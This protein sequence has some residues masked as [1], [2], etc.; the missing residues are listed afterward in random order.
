MKKTVGKAP[1]MEQF[2]KLLKDRELKATP[3]RLAVHEAML[4][5]THAGADSVAQ[6]IKEH[7][8]TDISVASVYNILSS[9][10]D[11][12][13]YKRRMSSNNKMYFD[14]IAS[15]HMHLYDT[16]FDEFKDIHDNNLLALLES[17]MKGRKFKGYKIDGM[18]VQIICHS[19]DRS[20]KK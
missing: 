15:D 19:T 18:D 11:E 10:A 9:L 13:I 4:A 14:V 7:S 2:R 17:Q 16:R 3:Q 12:K 6:Y 5:L 20:R 8:G 1:D